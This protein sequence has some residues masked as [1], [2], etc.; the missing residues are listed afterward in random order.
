MADAP[1]AA[2]VRLPSVIFVAL[3]AAQGLHRA[4]GRDAVPEFV[5]RLLDMCGA[6][7]CRAFA[8][9][10]GCRAAFPSLPVPASGATGL[11]DSVFHAVCC[12]QYAPLNLRALE[13][14]QGIDEGARPVEFIDDDDLAALAAAFER[15]PRHRQLRRLVL[16]MFDDLDA[17]GLLRLRDALGGLRS[18][19]HVEVILFGDACERAFDWTR[20]VADAAELRAL[21]L[22]QHRH[23]LLDLTPFPRLRRLLQSTGYSSAV[24]EEVRFPPSMQTIG[25]DAF[26]FSARLR[27]VSG[28]GAPLR[29]ICA[30]AFMG[31]AVETLDLSLCAALRPLPPA[32][33]RQVADVRL[34]VAR[35]AAP[36]H[37]PAPAPH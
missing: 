23:P 19:R 5:Y 17:A 8:S 12:I 27:H 2:M 1:A 31:T 6:R 33:Y 20:F 25:K 7:V 32:L 34:P 21:G 35:R 4:H 30:G 9:A 16:P 13:L 3:G 22:H 37:G 28:L 24:L 14:A 18:A 10:E 26:Q 36:C 11:D 15:H 29:E